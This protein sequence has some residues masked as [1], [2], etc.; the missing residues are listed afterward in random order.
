V[1]KKGR[2]PSA[3]SR[4]GKILVEKVVENYI[5]EKH[6]LCALAE[7]KSSTEVRQLSEGRIKRICDELIKEERLSIIYEGTG[8]PDIYIPSYMLQEILS[9]Q[10]K[11]SWLSNYE[12]K[13]KVQ[14][15]GEIEKKKQKI[16]T[17][18]SLEVLLYGSGRPLEKAFAFALKEIGFPDVKDLGDDPYKHD[19]E[20]KGNGFIMVC[21]VKGKQE[22]VDKDDVLQLNGWI[23]TYIEENS[24]V[25]PST[26]QGVLVVNH[27]K[28]AEPEDRWPTNKD[29]PPLT[30]EGKRFMNLYKYKF[31]TTFL[32]FDLVKKVIERNLNQKEAQTKILQGQKYE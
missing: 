12:F 4:S 25:D 27:Y 26:L 15:I 21:E 17:Y 16:F 18:E 5:L 30:Q 20:F 2:K 28:D 8:N 13:E 7:I 29:R 22:S 1:K 23:Q 10:R 31:V 11:P 3:P 14:I 24:Q 32:I 19:T 9:T 6:K